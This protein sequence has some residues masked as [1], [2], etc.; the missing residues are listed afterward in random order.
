MADHGHRDGE[1]RGAGHVATGEDRAGLPGQRGD[2]VDQLD[3]AVLIEAAWHSE[4][5]VGLA[6]LGAH[7]G[8]VGEGGGEGLAADLGEARLLAAEVDPLDDRVDR[9]CGCPAGHRDRR[10]VT[11]PDP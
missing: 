11:H 2:P 9:G 3:A 6:G 1:R 8:E 10:I 7:R 5:D 4:D